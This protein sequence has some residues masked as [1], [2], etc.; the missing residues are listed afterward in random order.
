MLRRLFFGVILLALGFVGLRVGGPYVQS[1]QFARMIRDEVQSQSVRLHPGAIHERVLELGK[2]MGLNLSDDD[3]SVGRA[4]DGFDVRVRYKVPVDLIWF[5]HELS[6]D[7]SEHIKPT[8]PP[9]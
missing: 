9:E 7:F 4:S 1:Y 5:Q 3:V 8:A 2:N 6:F